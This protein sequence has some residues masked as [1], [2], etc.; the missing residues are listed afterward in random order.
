MTFHRQGGNGSGLYFKFGDNEEFKFRCDQGNGTI[1]GTGPNGSKESG[2]EAAGIGENDLET[3]RLM[4]DG[5]YAKGYVNSVRV[6]QLNGL[7]FPRENKIQVDI[8]ER[9]RQR[10]A[11]HQHP[12]RGWRQEALRCP[13]GER[14]RGHA[15]DPLRREF[16]PDPR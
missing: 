10:V 6:G 4:V 13:G 8:A 5:G 14:P 1:Y 15:G 11:R 9:G 3:C 12:D 16:R 2:Q 7:V